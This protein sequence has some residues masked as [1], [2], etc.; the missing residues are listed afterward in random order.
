M[1]P[2]LLVLNS[3][4]SL[5]SAAW[6]VVALARP[7]FLS[8]SV[9]ISGGDKFY[10]RMYA[11]RAIPFGLATAIAPFCVGGTAVAWFLFTAAGIQVA[12]AVIGV[13]KKAR[14]MIIGATL[15]ALIHILCGLAVS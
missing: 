7:A 13:E 10:V 15:A 12:D 5:V 3:F 2:A 11:A 9:H 4:V 14:G 1:R 8:G 6:A